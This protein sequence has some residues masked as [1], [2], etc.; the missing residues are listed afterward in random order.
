MCCVVDL[1]CFNVPLYAC[2]QI[3]SC[4]CGPLLPYQIIIMNAL[5]LCFFVWCNIVVLSTWHWV[6]S[7]KSCALGMIIHSGLLYD[8]LQI[9]CQSIFRRNMVRFGA[10]HDCCQNIS[11]STV[12]WSVKKENH[13]HVAASFT[14]ECLDNGSSCLCEIKAISRSRNLVM[15]FG[16]TLFTFYFSVYLFIIMQ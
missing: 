3:C 9:S 13:L 7:V 2:D 8:S 6:E 15:F 14:N 4:F 10:S 12:L 11:L 1:S 5:A 16:F